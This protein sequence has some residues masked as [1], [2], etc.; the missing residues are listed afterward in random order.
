MLPGAFQMKDQ[1]NVC[2]A[3]DCG[4]DYDVNDILQMLIFVF[5]HDFVSF[6]L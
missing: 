4:P 2:T 1:K 5:R 3:F 6:V